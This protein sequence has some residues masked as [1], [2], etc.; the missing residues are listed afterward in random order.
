LFF[1]RK[2]NKALWRSYLGDK[3]VPK[4][5]PLL[6]KAKSSGAGLGGGIGRSNKSPFSP[7]RKTFLR[8]GPKGEKRVEN[9]R[10]ISLNPSVN[11]PIPK[12]MSSAKAG[13]FDS[14]WKRINALGKN[15]LKKPEVMKLYDS[16]ANPKGIKYLE[17][18]RDFWRKH[19]KKLRSYEGRKAGRVRSGDA[20]IKENLVSRIASISTYLKY[21]RSK[22]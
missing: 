16:F 9:Q 17:F 21:A 7:K 2:L 5:N 6:R 15:E 10:R 22:I 20:K 18:R 13:V 8:A 14:V 1:S 12:G 11:I 3:N 19:L 4:E